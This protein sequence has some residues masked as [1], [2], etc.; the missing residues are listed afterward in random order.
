MFLVVIEEERSLIRSEKMLYVR[1]LMS[2]SVSSI[3]HHPDAT[4]FS[5]CCLSACCCIP[6]LTMSIAAILLC[7]G[8]LQLLC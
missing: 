5:V 3:D 7:V 4:T 2:S 6:A 1:A 8:C